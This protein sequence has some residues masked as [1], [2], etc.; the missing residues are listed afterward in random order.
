MSQILEGGSESESSTNSDE[1][2]DSDEDTDSEDEDMVNKFK[3]KKTLVNVTARSS[4]L[5]MLEDGDK[6]YKQIEEI[7]GLKITK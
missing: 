5:K 1:E 6:M 7:F 4:E 2:T 3:S